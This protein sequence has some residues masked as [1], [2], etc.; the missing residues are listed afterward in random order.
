[1]HRRDAAS[2]SS[3]RPELVITGCGQLQE[4]CSPHGPIPFVIIWGKNR[5][6]LYISKDW[7]IRFNAWRQSRCKRCQSWNIL[8][9]KHSAS[10]GYVCSA[11]LEE[12]FLASSPPH[13][14]CRPLHQ[15]LFQMSWPDV[16]TPRP[17]AVNIFW[18]AGVKVRHNPRPSSTWQWWL[19]KLR[20]KPRQCHKAEKQ[21]RS[22]TE[23]G[24]G[25]K[26]QQC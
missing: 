26:K 22:L 21:Q 20:L 15:L 10:K 3:V 17:H 12:T 16:P 25:R 18:R 23:V 24:A 5:R 2:K 6:F 13:T 8:P 19:R 11:G 1:M 7:L 9:W 14:R 4:T